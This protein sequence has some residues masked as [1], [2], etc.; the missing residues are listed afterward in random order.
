M[1]ASPQQTSPTSRHSVESAPATNRRVTPMAK[2]RNETPYDDGY[3][4]GFHGR[5]Y[6]NPYTPDTD[7]YND[8]DSGF[9]NG[10]S[11][12]NSV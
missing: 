4:D 11:Y 10:R 12:R 1:G 2:S 8:Y 3:S 9:D 6:S 5:S 7:D